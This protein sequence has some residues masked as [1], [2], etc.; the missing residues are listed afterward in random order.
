MGLSTYS[1]KTCL[2]GIYASDCFP[3]F[4]KLI[5]LIIIFLIVYLFGCTQFCGLARGHYW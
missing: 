3:S 5:L 4:Y 2:G 1:P